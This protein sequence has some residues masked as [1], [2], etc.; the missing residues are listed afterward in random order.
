MKHFI[1]G[2]RGIAF[3]PCN[4][5]INLG[6]GRFAGPSAVAVVGS[7]GYVANNNLD[8]STFIP[9]GPGIITVIDL[10]NESSFTIQANGF[11]SNNL[12]VVGNEIFITNGGNINFN[13]VTSSFVCDPIFPPSVDVLNTG[14][15]NI[16]DTIEI[17]LS[18]V[19]E[20]VCFPGSFAATPDSQF[21]YLGLGLVG[22]LMKI[23]LVDKELINGA[24]NPI[25]VTDLSGLN[26]TSSVVIDE[27]GIGFTSLFNS[28][29][30]AVFNTSDDM[31]NP[32][33]A[34]APFPAGL[35]AFDP[36]SEFF[37][38]IQSL[39]LRTGANFSGPN[40]FFITGISEQLGS[41]N[42]N[43]ILP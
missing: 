16:T 26:N 32:F 7:T 41:V 21:A 4:E 43:I 2:S 42:A 11:S 35:R 15:N 14:S 18:E 28:D 22:A 34:I 29:Q 37:D 30:I 8:P 5:A 27:N 23:D 38:G 25:I 10:D 13:V 3:D 31:V 19:N 6:T 9:S 24:D 40:L 33:P 39:A 20:N 12:T 36:E 17:P 1:Q